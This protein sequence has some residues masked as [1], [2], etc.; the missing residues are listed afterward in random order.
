MNLDDA[1]V[2]TQPQSVRHPEQLREAEMTPARKMQNL[3]QARP[4]VQEEGS[5]RGRNVNNPARHPPSL[6]KKL[7]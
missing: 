5:G 1:N 7:E 2:Q 6:Q 3:Y 4:L